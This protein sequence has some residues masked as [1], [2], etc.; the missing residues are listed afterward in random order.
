MNVKK[1]HSLAEL[2]AAITETKKIAGLKRVTGPRA[3]RYVFPDST[4]LETLVQ[5]DVTIQLKCGVTCTSARALCSQHEPG[6][7]KPRLIHWIAR[8][9]F[10][11]SISEARDMIRRYGGFAEIIHHDFAGNNYYTKRIDQ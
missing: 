3:I 2:R 8:D 11:K 1:F 10:V 7:L 5:F 4:P 6:W 9:V